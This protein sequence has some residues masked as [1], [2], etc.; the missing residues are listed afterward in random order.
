[1]VDDTKKQGL[2][3]GE[4]WQNYV[5]CTNYN[6]SYLV[7]L[8]AQLLSGSLAPRLVKYDFKLTTS[9][10]NTAAFAQSRQSCFF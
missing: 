3:L 7:Y 8:V 6:D 5:I 9:S 1:M 2:I 10:P 4:G